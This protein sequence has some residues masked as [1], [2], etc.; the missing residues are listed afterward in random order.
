[1]LLLIYRCYLFY[2]QSYEK[3]LAFEPFVSEKMYTFAR[4]KQKARKF[5][6]K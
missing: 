2:V 1:V 6:W 5:L 3:S 4:Q